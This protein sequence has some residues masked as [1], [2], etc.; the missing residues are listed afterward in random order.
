MD[1]SILNKTSALAARAVEYGGLVEKY[2]VIV[3]ANRNEE[4]VL[5]DRVKIYGVAGKNKF[6]KLYNLW[7][8]AKILLEN[9]VYGII[10]VQDQYYLALVGYYLAKKF[11]LGLELQVHGFE[12]FYGWRKLIAKYVLP[13]AGAIRAVSRRLKNQLIDEF[14]VKQEK[15]TVVPIYCESRIKNQESKITKND[16]K[17]IFLTAG[18]L[19]AVKNIGMQI[20]AIAEAAR[21]CPN[22]E[23]WI[24]GDGPKREKLEKLSY[25]LRAASHVKFFGWQKDVSPYYLQAD[26]FMLTSHYEGWGLAVIEAG[27]FGL[28]IIMTD[29][30]CAGDVI[31]NNESGLVIPVGAKEKL[32]AAMLSIIRDDNLRK[33]LGKNAK[34]AASRLPDKEQTLK[35]Y[36]LS[37]ETAAENIL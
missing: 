19:A 2:T 15:I 23:L 16:N 20:E 22:L 32:V 27:Q 29:V 25:R 30:G 9:A 14:G 7:R 8:Q 37:W 35:L 31:I 6:I 18:R 17:F 5:S 11:K 1:N 24:I 4:S 33:K 12:K 34:L 36:K 21:E 26:A 13:R 3:P 10:T 28:P